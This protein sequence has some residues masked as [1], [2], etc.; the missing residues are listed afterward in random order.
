[1]SNKSFVACLITGLACLVGSVG[2]SQGLR[3]AEI[4]AQNA[5]NWT[6]AEKG[7]YIVKRDGNA[8]WVDCVKVGSVN[9]RCPTDFPKEAAGCVPFPGGLQV[10]KCSK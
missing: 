9:K 4:S 5:N 2:G 7:A 10:R 1:M 6:S 3:I 8:V